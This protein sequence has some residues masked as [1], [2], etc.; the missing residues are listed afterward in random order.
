M[1]RLASIADG[2][3]NVHALTY[4]GADLTQVADGL[5]RTL[6]LAYSS[7]RLASV[8]DGTRTVSFAYTGG[9]LTSVTDAAGK[10][11]TYDYV[12][13]GAQLA[14]KI[15]PTGRTPLT[16]SYDGLGRVASQTTPETYTTS[17]TYDLP[18]SRTSVTDPLGGVKEH[19][20]DGA[21]RLTGYE[22]ESGSDAALA[23]DSAG[24]RTSITDRLGRTTS[25]SYHTTSGFVSQ[26]TEADGRR[27]TLT[28]AARIV[29]A[30]LP[31][32]YV[33]VSSRALPQIRFYER[34]STTVLNAAVGPILAGYVGS[35]AQ[36]LA[37]AGFRGTLL[38]MQGKE[39]EQ[40]AEFGEGDIGAVAKLKDV[41]TG[42][43]LLDKEV[44]VEIPGFSFPE[45]VMSFAITPKAKGDEEKM[46]QAVRRLIE[47]DP[48]LT[49]RRDPQTGE[50]LLAG[51]SQMH[52][53]VAVDRRPVA[54]RDR[55]GKFELV[56]DHAP[57]QRHDP[58]RDGDAER[59]G[60]RDG[61][62]DRPAQLGA[63]PDARRRA[64]HRL[65]HQ[66]PRSDR[67]G[68]GHPPRGSR[69]R[70][71]RHALLGASPDAPVQSDDNGDP[72]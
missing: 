42:D 41:Q 72:R 67:R 31:G 25:F 10:V 52:V 30:R 56:L 49:V 61:P 7:G 18:G 62:G 28:Y 58:D 16:Q 14:A 36:R 27:T 34:T 3:G 54:A 35:L 29:E 21:A 40:T 65:G 47:E 37:A 32:V 9:V 1:S 53:E 4:T 17:F 44:E 46:G 59:D 64:H 15:L 24:R 48:T 19:A 33:S 43:L 22:D 8:T 13:G 63:G 50:Q 51:L 66:G 12:P 55:P 68:G 20:H 39:H 23:Y 70:A 11:T 71:A 26:V 2:R 60:R 6:T 45:P 5:G 38:V 57:H 69:R